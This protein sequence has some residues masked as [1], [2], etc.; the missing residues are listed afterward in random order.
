MHHLGPNRLDSLH[1]PGDGL[2][3]RL[4]RLGARKERPELGLNVPVQARDVTIET[5]DVVAER[6]DGC[7]DASNFGAHR[8]GVLIELTA[9]EASGAIRRGDGVEDSRHVALDAGGGLGQFAPQRLE[10]GIQTRGPEPTGGS[11]HR[12][13]TVRP[14]GAKDDIP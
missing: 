2:V 8:R 3:Q 1:E 7:V 13:D 9:E 10:L 11:S 6:G 14:S 5:N 4:E 12:A